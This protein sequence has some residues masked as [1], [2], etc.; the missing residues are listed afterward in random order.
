VL[1]LS[2]TP[3]NSGHRLVRQARFT[4][5]HEHQPLRT[6]YAT[7]ALHQTSPDGELQTSQFLTNALVSPDA[8]D[9]TTYYQSSLTIRRG[10]MA[11]KYQSAINCRSVLSDLKYARST[12]ASFW[13]SEPGRRSS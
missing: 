9:G 11:C 8:L 2:I 1:Q 7:I 6:T 10:S 13:A 12:V 4:S 3:I 5:E